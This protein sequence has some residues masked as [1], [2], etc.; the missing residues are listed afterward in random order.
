M[1]DEKIEQEAFMLMAGFL[2]EIE[3]FQTLSDKYNKR[4]DLAKAIGTFAS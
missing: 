4:K 2:S 3:A 1:G